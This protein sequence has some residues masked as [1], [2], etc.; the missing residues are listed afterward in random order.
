[1]TLQASGTISLNDIQTEFGGAS[2]ISLNE[3]YRGGG[4]VPNTAQ[5]AAI[6]TSGA[7][8]LSQFYGTSAETSEFIQFTC[9]QGSG[10]ATRYGFSNAG[11]VPG[12]GS[13]G[14]RSPTTYQGNT[15]GLFHNQQVSPTEWE[16]EF[17]IQ[18]SHAQS[19]FSNLSFND[20]SSTPRSLFSGST[21]V[22]GEANGYTI[23]RWS[24]DSIAWLSNGL[25]RTVTIAI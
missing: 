21:I 4:L 14:S 22:F 13:Y 10:G 24:A 6:P 11:P 9:G 12:Y 1:M 18:G 8:S 2:P 7:I 3:Y 19:K 15:I 20:V 17:A 5:N 16:I 25:V 23:W